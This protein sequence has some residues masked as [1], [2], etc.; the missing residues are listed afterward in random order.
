[1]AQN[2]LNKLVWLVDTINRARSITFDEIN[3]KW[4]DNKDLNDGG[5]LSKRTFHKWKNAIFDIFGLQIDC[6]KRGEYRYYI[7]NMDDLHNGSV[8]KWL[9]STCSVSNS[10]IGCRAIK[11]RIVLENVPSGLH[12]LD[13]VIDAMK[14]NCIVEIKYYNYMRGDVHEYTLM[15]LCVK[16]F[17]QRWYMVGKACDSDFIGIFCFDRIQ[18]L[19]VTDRSFDY[20]EDFSPQSYFDGFYGV[21]HDMDVAV[22]T[23]VLKSSASQANYIRDLPLMHGDAQMETERCEDY[24]IFEIRVRPTYD[25]MQELLWHR[26]E[27]EVLKPQWLRDEMLEIIDCMRYKYGETD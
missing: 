15:P 9:L 21:F 2:Q 4:M 17:K 19:K 14:R 3:R 12:Y 5:E 10:L 13:S 16:L 8:E 25:F 23:V 11:D 20:P 1:M 27:I 6:E 24:S 7:A 26:D 18:D 22:E